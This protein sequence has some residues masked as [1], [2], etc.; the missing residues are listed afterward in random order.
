MGM[1]QT[2]DV[3]ANSARLGWYHPRDPDGVPLCGF[4]PDFTK[5]SQ[6]R[7]FWRLNNLLDQNPA[8]FSDN[9]GLLF[10]KTSRYDNLFVKAASA[11]A[12]YRSV[13]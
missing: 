6:A 11:P 2:N 5:Y 9:F 12:D 10:T 7:T 4:L 13:R 3:Y 1:R 8:N